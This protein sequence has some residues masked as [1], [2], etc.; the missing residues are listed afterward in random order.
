MID[1]SVIQHSRFTAT[2]RN[3]YFGPASASTLTDFSVVSNAFDVYVCPTCSTN[4]ADPPA[5]LSSYTY[6]IDSL[7]PYM[8]VN[9]FTTVH[10]PCSDCDPTGM[11]VFVS[12][13]NRVTPTGIDSVL[14]DTGT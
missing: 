11:D 12:S 9:K 1:T 7:Q 13:T 2:C 5:L 6:V 3:A 8:T 4:M 14:V 10:S